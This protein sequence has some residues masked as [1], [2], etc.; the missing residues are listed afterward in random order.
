M[1]K[2][3]EYFDWQYYG[4]KHYES[5][6]TKFYQAYILPKKFKVDKRQVHLSDL[7]RNG[8][9]TYE[10]AE[11]EFNEVI[12][13]DVELKRDREFFLKKLSFSEDEF[14]KIMQ[15]KPHKHDEYPTDKSYI[16]FIIKVGKVVKVVYKKIVKQR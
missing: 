3:H 16:N 5:K 8:E 15:E 6:F 2:L 9:I 14:S 10:E 7:M 13:D 1:E 4:G 11:A 12:Y